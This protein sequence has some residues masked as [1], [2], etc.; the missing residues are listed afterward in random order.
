[1][2]RCILL[3]TVLAC[4]LA[5]APPTHSAT[6]AEINSYFRYVTGEIDTLTSGFPDSQSQI[7]INLAQEKIVTL[8][9]YIPLSYDIELSVP[10]SLDYGLPSTYKRLRPAGAMYKKNNQWLGMFENPGFKKDTITASFFV[11]WDTQDSARIY[12][13]G[14]Y[15]ENEDSVR[16]FYLGRA[17]WMD[18][19]AAVCE[20]PG[21]L[22]PLM[23]EQAL[24]YYEISNK[25][26]DIESAIYQQ[27]RTDMGIYKK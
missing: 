26:I 6:L 15:L 1:M 9:G 8:G 18:S 20:V 5:F 10:D 19:T 23:I 7:W 27:T 21:D 4:A 2:K 16:V 25:R 22:F 24:M 11:E 3:V 17:T 12:V 14:S 13:K